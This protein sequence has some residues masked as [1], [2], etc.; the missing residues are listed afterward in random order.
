MS[1]LERLEH[2]MKKAAKA[3]ESERLGVIRFVRSQTKNR[4]IELGR[5]LTD[6]DVVGVLARLAKQHR[7]SIDQFT[8]GGRE[9]LVESEKRK[10]AVLSEYLP[11]PLDDAELDRII[12]EVIEETGATGPSDMGPVMKG[13]MPRVKGRVE[14]GRVKSLVQARL[15]GNG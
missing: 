1:I 8:E 10:L 3:R 11:E 9:E 12:T 13:I 14:G 15:S 5:E 4:E 7:E 6:E 2:D